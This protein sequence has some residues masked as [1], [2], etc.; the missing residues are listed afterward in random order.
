M[1][2]NLRVQEK[3]PLKNLPDL[4]KA[5]RAVEAEL[6]GSGRLLIRYSGTE[7]KLRIL[8]EAESEAHAHQLMQ[9]IVTEACNSLSIH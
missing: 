1:T 8:I 4:Q 3:I 7:F 9:I 6:A 5:I 2:E